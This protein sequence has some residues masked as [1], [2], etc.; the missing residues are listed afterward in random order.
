M[1]SLLKVKPFSCYNASMS[2]VWDY[3]EKQLKQ[4]ESGRL[5]LLERMINYGPRNGEK[6]SLG[7]VKKHWNKLNLFPKNKKLYDSQNILSRL[8]VWS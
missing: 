6:I 3:D 2:I 8:Q 1:L 5:L 7:Q 4:T